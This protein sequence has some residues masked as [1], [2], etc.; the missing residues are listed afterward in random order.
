MASI[1]QP[2]SQCLSECT[3]STHASQARRMNYQAPSP[4]QTHL[5]KTSPRKNGQLRYD[6]GVHAMARGIRRPLRLPAACCLAGFG[7]KRGEGGGRGVSQRSVSQ[8]LVV[9]RLLAVRR[10]VLGTTTGRLNASSTTY[11][12]PWFS[13][14]GWAGVSAQGRR[15]A[16]STDLAL[17]R[18]AES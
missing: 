6:G 3:G 16:S 5:P 4:S 14:G 10:R 13:L 11:Y 8:R 9:S 7:G 17:P 12:L 2:V 18:G 15:L 1:S